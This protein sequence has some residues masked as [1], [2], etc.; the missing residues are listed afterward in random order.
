[1]QSDVFATNP[2]APT[3]KDI[4]LV[5]LRPGQQMEMEMHAVKGAKFSPYNSPHYHYLSHLCSN[6]MVSFSSSH[7]NY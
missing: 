3:N 1:M 2:P 6:G 4:V 7:K 5:K